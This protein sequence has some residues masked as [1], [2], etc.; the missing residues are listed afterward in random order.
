VLWLIVRNIRRRRFK[1]LA[2]Y[3]VVLLA[4][5]LALRLTDADDLRFLVQQNRFERIAAEHPAPQTPHSAVCMFFDRVEDHL[6]LGGMS[7]APYEK[8][9][10]FVSPDLAGQENPRIDSFSWADKRCVGV[11]A[12]RQIKHLRGRFY[13]ADSFHR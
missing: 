13:L 5:P 2:L 1:R 6:Y 7:F 10:L 8:M 12:L 4:L 3:A 9:V 11:T